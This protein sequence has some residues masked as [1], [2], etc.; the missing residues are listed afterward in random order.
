MNRQIKLV[1]RPT[2]NISDDC[3]ERV[4]VPI[5]E[6]GD[7]EALVRTL[8]LSLDP[9]MR[10]WMN[11]GDS[12][13]APVEL[14]DVMRGGTLGTVVAS[15]CAELG[16]GDIVFGGNGWQDYAVARPKH[17]QKVPADSGLP[18]SNYLS[19]LG[20]TGLTAYFGMLDVGKPQ[21]GETVVV[22]T[23]AGAVGSVAGQIAAIQGS[24]V[25]GLAGSDDKCTW[26]TEELGF[27][28]CINYKTED[29][30]D[31]LR[32][33]CPDKVDVYFDNVGG[34]MLNTVLGM[35]K[36][37]ARFVICGAISQYN[38]TERTPGPSNYIRL[39][40]KRSTMQ[41]F[42]VLDYAQRYPE[43][44]RQLAAWVMAGK[45][46]HREDIVDGLDNAPQAIHKLF[47]GSNAGKL[48]VRVSDA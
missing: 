12:Y 8:Y 38:A 46:K 33:A 29:W 32:A 24:R 25:V 20:I 16:E 6:P 34:D 44:I 37:G 15:N 3:F 1:Q 28:A 7:G 30:K 22:S 47:D 11:E 2:G 36:V 45:I 14:G 35:N 40:T 21:P 31:Q 19:V 4:E 13:I 18:L 27:D 39:L 26:C 10:G 41:G 43:G 9:A 23:A 5:P 48:M 42:V 17:L